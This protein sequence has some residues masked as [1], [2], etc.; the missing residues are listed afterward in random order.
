MLTAVW[1]EEINPLVVEIEK[2]D[3]GFINFPENNISN[4]KKI[5]TSDK[6]PI[7]SS[8]D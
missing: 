1:I 7:N 5:I 8:N 2:K 6:K 3:A 4:S